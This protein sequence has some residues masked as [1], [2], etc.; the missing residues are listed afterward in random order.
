MCGRYYLAPDDGSEELENIRR[1]IESRYGEDEAALLQSGEIF[2]SMR[3]P[4]VLTAAGGYIAEPMTW[5]FPSFRG[6]QLLINARS[7][8][9]GEKPTFR[10]AMEHGRCIIPTSGFYEWSHDEAGRAVDKYLIQIPE[11]KVLYLAGLYRRF[12]DEL[13]FVILTQ[14]SNAAMAAIHHRMP[15]AIPREA[16]A[17][18]I[19][20]RTVADELIRDANPAWISAIV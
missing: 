13:R 18:Y 11:A 15:V 20:R 9:A 16:L 5:G 19:N 10:E 8:T 7:E 6:K 2:P 12:D 3:V 14:D 1:Y 17:D 4:V